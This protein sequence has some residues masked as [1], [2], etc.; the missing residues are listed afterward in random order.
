M[1]ESSLLVYA[2]AVLVLLTFGISLSIIRF[3]SNRNSIKEPYIEE[4]AIVEFDEMIIEQ[5]RERIAQELS[6]SQ[7]METKASVLVAY[8]GV[9][10]TLVISY[11]WSSYLEIFRDKFLLSIPFIIGSTFLVVSLI[12]AL[13]I[14]KPR[15]RL[16]LLNPRTANNRFATMPIEEARDQV[17]RNL[18]QNFSEIRREVIKDTRYISSGF[19]TGIIGSVLLV[20]P[21]IYNAIS[22]ILPLISK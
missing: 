18:L 12:A 9:I 13:W 10:G 3:R 20:I 19:W 17:K 6:I 7:S 14:I 15:Q 22:E 21:F 5:T 8:V 16:N 4:S 11:L 2:Y 1:A